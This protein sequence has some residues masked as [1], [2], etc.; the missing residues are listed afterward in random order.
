MSRHFP[1]GVRPLAP[2]LMATAFIG[3]SPT[4]GQ[5][6]AVRRVHDP[7]LINEGDRYYLF[8]TG[9]GTPVKTSGDLV[10][11]QDAGRVFVE[12]LPEWARK[13]I[14][15]SRFPWAPDISFFGGEYHLYYSVSTFGSQRSCIGLATN[16][17]LDPASKDFRWIDR[18]MVLDSRPGRDD[19]NAIDPNVVLDEG[20]RPWMSFGSFF[21]GIKLVQLDPVTGRLPAD[22]GK[23]RHLAARPKPNAVEAPYIVRRGDD[24]YLFVSFDFCCRGAKSDYNIVVGRSRRVEGPYLDRDGKAMTEGGGSVVLAGQGNVRGPG[25]NAVLLQAGGDL[26]VHHYYDADDEGIAKLQVRSL[27]WSDDGWPIA[28]APLGSK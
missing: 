26:L 17:T 15:G 13:E 14:P 21:G 9:R 2:A 1:F 23:I 4:P 28:G 18:G 12:S 20:G 6:D 11:W 8:S 19:F 24:Y 7:C 16:K 3:V 10:R 27:T 5:Q 25:H 22:G